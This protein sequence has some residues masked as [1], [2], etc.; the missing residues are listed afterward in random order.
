MYCVAIFVAALFFDADDELVIAV[1]A[2]AV[3]VV[4]LLGQ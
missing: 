2:I 3:E 4:V 1:L